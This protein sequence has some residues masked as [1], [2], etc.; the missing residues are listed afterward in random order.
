MYNSL[1]VDFLNKFA[2]AYNNFRLASWSGNL[3]S[4]NTLHGVRAYYNGKT[5]LIWENFYSYM[6]KNIERNSSLAHNLVYRTYPP[7]NSW[8]VGKTISSIE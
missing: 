7:N 4:S 8:A 3:Y 2:P 5:L 6:F 1:C